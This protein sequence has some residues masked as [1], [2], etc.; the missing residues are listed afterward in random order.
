METRTKHA[1]ELLA[2]FGYEGTETLVDA[3]ENMS[4]SEEWADH[5]VSGLDYSTSTGELLEW[6]QDKVN[7]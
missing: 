3:D 2:Y 5:A 7:F 6:P 1:Q 4:T